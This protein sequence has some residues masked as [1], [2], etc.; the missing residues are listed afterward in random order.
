MSTVAGERKLSLE[1][2]VPSSLPL[3]R[4]D[5]TRLEQVIL[6]LLTNAFKWS[7]PEGKI[8]L[9]AGEKDAS[10]VI[11]IQDEGAGISEKDKERI[12]DAY[13]RTE[14]DRQ[15]IDGLGLGLALCKTIVEAHN[16]EIRVESEKGKGS[17]FSFSIPLSKQ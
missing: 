14:D 17:T 1:L 16:G 8:T 5:E 12:F 10:L 9:R 2:D 15:R 3:I 7:R 4:G 13:Y 11:E 6:N